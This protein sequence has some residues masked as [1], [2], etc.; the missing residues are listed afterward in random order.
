MSLS[1]ISHAYMQWGSSCRHS[2]GPNRRHAGKGWL[3]GRLASSR[4]LF[5]T[6]IQIPRG[7][8]SRDFSRSVAPSPSN[9]AA[10]RGVLFR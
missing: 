2:T 3:R 1:R 4:R 8:R 6:S 7:R 5:S 10:H 9:L